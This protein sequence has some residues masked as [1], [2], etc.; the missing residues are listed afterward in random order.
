[1]TVLWYPLQISMIITAERAA[2]MPPAPV[3]DG[4]ELRGYREGDEESWRALINTGAFG[5][6]WPRS[7]FDEYLNGRERREGS[8]LAVK[9]GRVLAATFASVEDGS[10]SIAVPNEFKGMG[11]LDFVISHPDARR[12]GLGRAVCSAVVKY[13]FAQGYPNVILWTDNWRI[14]AIA[15][16]LSMGFEPNLHR[17]DMPERWDKVMDDLE[18][19]KRTDNES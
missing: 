17:G 11:R 6:A 18:A 4:Y 5:T 7:K 1:M 19:W 8:R 9:D 10:D 16:Y 14:P 15:M 2:R 3:P 13:L 12:L